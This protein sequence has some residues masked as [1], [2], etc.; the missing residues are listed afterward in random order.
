MVAFEFPAET[1]LDVIVTFDTKAVRM[2]H[3]RLRMRY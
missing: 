2:M 3:M 1:K